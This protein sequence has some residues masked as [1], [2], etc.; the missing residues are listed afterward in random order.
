MIALF[1][2]RFKPCQN[3][4]M[5]FFF[6]NVRLYVHIWCGDI[7]AGILSYIHSLTISTSNIYL[8]FICILAATHRVVTKTK[9][10]FGPSELITAVWETQFSTLQNLWNTSSIP[11]HVF[12]TE[13]NLVFLLSVSILHWEVWGRSHIFI[14][15][16]VKEERREIRKMSLWIQ[17]DLKSLGRW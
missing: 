13:Y 6:L 3:I 5:W 14:W 2:L 7:S 10:S 15:F 8:I 17:Q 12:S 4:L 11:L 1:L 9:G 16:R